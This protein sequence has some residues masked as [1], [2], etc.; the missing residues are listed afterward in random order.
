MIITKENYKNYNI[1]TKAKNL[2]Y[3]SEKGINI[4]KFFCTDVES[5]D[6][7]ADYA[8]KHFPNK[9]LFSVRSSSSVE[10]S[11]DSS[12]A[13]QF[14]T[15]LNVAKDELTNYIEKTA[16]GI[17]NSALKEYCQRKNIKF[18]NVKVAVI[19]QEMIDAELSGVIFTA[20]PQ[21]L[22]NETVIAV[23]KGTGDNVVEDKTEITTYYYNTT[24]KIYYCEK[25]NDSPLLSNKQI[26]EIISVSCKI[27]KLFGYECD[28]EFAIKN[29]VLY[30]LQAR[31]ITTLLNNDSPIILDNSNIVESYPGITLPLTQSFIKEA[32][33]CVFRSLLLRL[34]KEKNT[35]KQADHI[36]HTM[37]DACNGRIYYRISNWYD[38]IMFLPFH[39]K[40]IPVWQEMLGVKNKTVTCHL[41]NKIGFVTHT[42]VTISFFQLLFQCPTL[43]KQLDRYFS[44]VLKEFSSVDISSADSLTVLK[45]YNRI[46]SMVTEKWDITLV[47]DMYSF[48]YTGLLKAYLKSKK[49]KNPEETANRLISGINGI[50][51][52]KPVNTLIAI[53]EKA[54]KS[55][56]LDELEKICLNEDFYA[57]IKENNDSFTRQLTK[58]IEIYG[59]RNVNE[60]KLESK[61]FRTDPILLVQK[62]V[63]Y[64]RNNTKISQKEKPLKAK[65]MAGFLAKRAALG[66]KNRE[67]SR[68]HRSRL[69]GMMRSM[70]LRIGENLS[71]QK[72]IS[73]KEDIFM[74]TYNEVEISVKNSLNMKNT[75]SERKKQY[76]MF[77]KLP[78]Y[79]RLVF[80]ANVFDKNPTSIGDMKFEN[81]GNCF[82]GT[83][84][85]SGKV[86]GEVLIVEDPT[87]E[88][89][90]K[91]KILVTKMTDPG[92]V[93][94]IAA[95]K[96]I[97]AEKGSLL[98]HTAIISRELSKPAVVGVD[99]ITNL[100]KN[101]DVISI[102]GGSGEIRL[103]RRKD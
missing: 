92:W 77:A 67:K 43:I 31:P 56:R 24:D 98:S 96:G 21:G 60:L 101:G 95:A 1:G 59:D 38:I 78:A 6:T 48:I 72:L 80:S 89:N 75:I 5:S 10:D 70:M 19:V 94:L 65:G 8:K 29:R 44:S 64:G 41:K 32:Y 4:P 100:L 62:I 87:V 30:I 34:T 58:Y 40:I 36:L 71:A 81:S 52:M 7:A 63:Q 17:N 102:D 53:S 84:C 74:L 20:N 91:D 45:H 47:N 42:K 61:T 46:K 68:L 50:E 33:Y 93:F 2:F 90:A 27:K 23:G 83:P 13:G 69:Y 51:S 16:K 82:T 35:V 76:D 11:T 12:F 25:Q 15:F 9:E 22:I 55:G 73:Q 66:I 86:S 28:I 26:E 85:S 18:Q 39:K 3:M 54:K 57:Y 14:K 79:S 103:L 49:V 37:V 88:I 97:V 99:N